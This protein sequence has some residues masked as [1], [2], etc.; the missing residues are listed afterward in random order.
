MHYFPHLKSFV[1]FLIY[2]VIVV[3][4]CLIIEGMHLVQVIPEAL[5]LISGGSIIRF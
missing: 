1:P 5:K 3:M 2:I 4:D